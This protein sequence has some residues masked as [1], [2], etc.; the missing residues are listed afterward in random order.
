MPAHFAELT[1]IFRFFEITF[2]PAGLTQ[3]NAIILPSFNMITFSIL[4]VANMEI[5]RTV[6]GIKHKYVEQALIK[7]QKTSGF[8][9]AST[10]HI[11]MP[12]S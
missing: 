6:M 5:S 9:R 2:C 1:E 10:L 4:H 12:Y 8:L 11:N 7:Y 3:Q